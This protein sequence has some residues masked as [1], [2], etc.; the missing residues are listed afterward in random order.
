MNN[1]EEIL[2]F[3]GIDTDSDARYVANGDYRESYYC[4]G[5]SAHGYDGAQVS[6]IGTILVNN[7]G[8][9]SGQN[10]I[11]GSCGWVEDRSIVFFLYN[12]N[13]DHQIWKYNTE[14]ETFDLV[15]QDSVL[16]FSM[17]RKIVNPFVVNGV[18]YWT[19]GF[20]GSFLGNNTTE[21]Y[22]YN[23]PR[24]LD[25]Q[26]AIDGDYSAFTFQLLD[27]VRWPPRFAPDVQTQTDTNF[28]YNFIY[29]RLFQFCYR[30][31]YDDNQRSA[32]SPVSALALYEEGYWMTGIVANNPQQ[33]NAIEIQYNTGPEYVDRIEI[34]YREGNNGIWRLWR[35]IDKAAEVLPDNTT[36][37]VNFYNDTL[38]NAVN[39]GV[40]QSDAFPIT[41]RAQ[42]F[43][44]SSEIA[45]A[46]I[47]EGYDKV[48]PDITVEVTPIEIEDENGLAPIVSVQ[49][50]T[51][52]PFNSIWTFGLPGY[53]GYQEGDVIVF[54]LR[55]ISSTETLFFTVTTEANFTD[56]INAVE[57]FLVAAGYT[58]TPDIPNRRITI[59]GAQLAFLG[60]VGN[61]TGRAPVIRL[62]HPKT[63]FK[64]GSRYIFAIQYEDRANRPGTVFQTENLTVDIPWITDIDFSGF[65]NAR[66]PFYIEVKLTI[67]NIPPTW[68]THYRVVY[69]PA[70]M[71]FNAGQR[72]VN[73]I[74][75][76]VDNPARLNVSLETSYTTNYVGATLDYTPQPGDRLRF[77]RR[78]QDWDIAFNFQAEYLTEQIDV[79]VYYYGPGEGNDGT[80]LCIVDYFDWTQI[81]VSGTQNLAGQS[82]L[83]EIYRPYSEDE[84]R[85][86][87]VTNT[88]FSII[89]PHTADR[90]HNGDVA[91]VLS[92]ASGAEVFLSDAYRKDGD[93]YIRPRVLDAENTTFLAFTT[94]TWWCESKSY[95]DYFVSQ[96]YSRGAL[97]PDNP[98]GSQKHL[99]GTVIHSNKLL[100]NTLINGLNTME[101]QNRVVVSDENGEI[102][103]IIQ[104]GYTLNV[105]QDNKVSAIYN[106]KSL[107]LGGDGNTNVITSTSATFAQVRPREQTYG[108]IDSSAAIKVD[109]GIYYYDRL[110]A[111]VIYI[112]AGGQEDLT[113]G[114]YKCVKLFQDINALLDTAEEYY[115]YPYHDVVNREI[116]FQFAYKEEGPS[117]KF[118]YIYAVFNYVKGRW[119]S[120][121]RH[122]SDWSQNLGDYL[123]SWNSGQLY[124]YNQGPYLNFLGQPQTQ[125]LKYVCASKM[126][127]IGNYTGVPI[128]IWR[129]VALKTNSVWSLVANILPNASYTAMQTSI[130]AT[131]WALREGFYYAPYKRDQN[132]PNF[133][134]TA[135]AE[136]NGRQMRGYE[137]TN[138][139]SQASTS[140]VIIWSST[141]QSQNSIAIV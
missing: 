119:T 77:I 74:Q 140:Q 49:N 107:V 21:I 137:I 120:L 122:Q 134:T 51:P 85:P 131:S 116:V 133:V 50:I 91:Q 105:L 59:V 87:F 41:A 118:T 60:S 93:W 126:V 54:Q 75:S 65:T 25:I 110:N 33:D 61:P 32:L 100:D 1:K 63:T 18:L 130:P 136:V 89:D 13:L 124:K 10:L 22:G 106:Q 16:N 82:A 17:Q 55:T 15:M 102:C 48:T 35:S 68:A 57:V 43:L 14:D 34:L 117:G 24:R 104:D 29:G 127:K 90:R 79:Q 6:M 81:G 4:R 80:D 128:R 47:R 113:I 129:A 121:M 9:P 11:I 56:L 3:G 12:S 111:K 26:K 141:V 52:P 2:F 139:I 108:C 19:D 30:Y 88:A 73:A 78:V 71:I 58:V 5:M 64:L 76:V 38:G 125:S 98:N 27:A 97:A 96:D 92:P 112:N 94:G 31:I 115:I 20:F 42:E 45:Y 99:I 46:N 103:R 72:T 123:V 40:F 95:S 66:A 37:I 135:L 67:D 109:W 83:C 36:E 8:L 44:P 39:S 23:P 138:T 62:V 28:A 86:F 84:N 53:Y 101:A 132:T 114:K 7:A 70:G 69:K